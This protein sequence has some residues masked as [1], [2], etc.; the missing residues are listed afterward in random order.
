MSVQLLE[1]S[2]VGEKNVNHKGEEFL[3]SDHI[4]AC[5]PV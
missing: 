3:R 2:A 5:K 4:N 1:L